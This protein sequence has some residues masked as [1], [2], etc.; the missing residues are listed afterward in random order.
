LVF[1]S[2]SCWPQ[3]F[4]FFT[5]FFSGA[6]VPAM[7]PSFIDPPNMLSSSNDRG[8][9]TSDGSMVSFGW[10]REGYAVLGVETKLSARLSTGEFSNLIC[11]E[12]D[13]VMATVMVVCGFNVYSCDC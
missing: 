4:L 7:L 1:G 10:K 11:G 6:G 9:M 2:G 12:P 3:D 13:I 5:G 8:V